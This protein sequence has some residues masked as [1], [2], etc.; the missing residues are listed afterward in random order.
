MATN[1]RLLL[2]TGVAYVLGKKRNEIRSKILSGSIE[3][4]V[5]SPDGMELVPYIKLE[6]AR[7][8]AI[9]IDARSL[10]KGDIVNQLPPL[11]KNAPTGEML[12]KRGAAAYLGCTTHWL[13]TLAETGKIPAYAYD[14]AGIELRIITKGA[15][16][17]GRVLHF[18]IADLEAYKSRIEAD[19]SKPHT[20]RASL[21][22]SDQQKE[23]IITLANSQMESRGY[24][25]I[26]PIR[27]ALA[28]PSNTY[29]E[30]LRK[31]REE[32]GWPMSHLQEQVSKARAKKTV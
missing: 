23:Q 24:V 14:P 16:R 8:A 21:P 7:H 10:K 11:P 20:K 13:H 17:R 1:R 32:Q 15:S 26:R 29:D 25:A 12:Q 27:I 22:L 18:R 9:Y 28:L 30:A 5:Y 6:R 4:L 31:L 3:A 19:K 2:P